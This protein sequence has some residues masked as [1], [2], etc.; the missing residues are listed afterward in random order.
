MLT[1]DQI[2]TESFRIIDAEVGEQPFSARE[3]PVV[4]RMI[5]ASGDT[6]LVNDVRFHN[7]PVASGLRALAQPVSISAE[8]NSWRRKAC[9]PASA[10]HCAGSTPAS[11]ST[12]RTLSKSLRYNGLNQRRPG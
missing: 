7:D 12:M 9:S 1:P 6:A 5:H 10:F 3:W 4:R 11:E 8:R 2:M